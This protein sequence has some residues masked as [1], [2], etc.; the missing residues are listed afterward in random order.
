MMDKANETYSLSEHTY[1]IWVKSCPRPRKPW[2]SQKRGVLWSDQE[3]DDEIKIQ[4]QLWKKGFTHHSTEFLPQ[5]NLQKKKIKQLILNKKTLFW[6]KVNRDR[7]IQGM[8]KLIRY[9]RSSKSEKIITKANKVLHSDEV[10]AQKLVTTFKQNSSNDASNYPMFHPKGK[11]L[12]AGIVSDI[13]KKIKS[14]EVEEVIRRLN[15]RKAPGIDSISNDMIKFG[16]K[17]MV[18]ILRNFFNNILISRKYPSEWN[19]GRIIPIPKTKSKEVDVSDF[20]PISLLSNI[21]K[22]L[23]K[24]VLNRLT[25]ENCIDLLIPANQTGFKKGFSTEWN[26]AMLHSRIHESRTKKQLT[27]LVFLDIKAAYDQVNRGILVKILQDTF[28]ECSIMSYF[29]DFL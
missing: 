10:I 12:P 16:G 19:D 29:K 14:H 24:V 7:D 21:S 27:A 11:Q 25:K 28:G 22:V 18:K 26:L 5:L 13:N 15:S 20:R 4:N 6:E 8:H 17:P 2:N 23:E 1:E 3:I 9:L